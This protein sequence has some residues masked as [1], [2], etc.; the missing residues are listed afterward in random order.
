MH[1]LRNLHASLSCR[2]Y[3]R[4]AAAFSTSFQPISG[5]VEEVIHAYTFSAA[6]LVNNVAERVALCTY[7][8]RPLK[9]CSPDAEQ[10]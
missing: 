10:K 7:T 1:A 2:E 6:F 4:S 9:S 8:S 5:T 3:L